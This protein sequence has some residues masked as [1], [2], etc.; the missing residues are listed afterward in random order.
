MSIQTLF[1][2][3]IAVWGIGVYTYLLLEES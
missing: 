3:M 2:L 1:A